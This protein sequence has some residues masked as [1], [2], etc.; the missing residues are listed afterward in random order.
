MTNDALFKWLCKKYGNGEIQPFLKYDRMVKHP[1]YIK[2]LLENEKE[3]NGLY[4]RVK[5]TLKH[6]IVRSEKGSIVKDLENT[7]GAYDVQVVKNSANNVIKGVIITVILRNH[8]WV[9]K[10]GRLTVTEDN[11]MSGK[12]AFAILKEELEKD[13]VK[14]ADYYDDDGEQYKAEIDAYPICNCILHKEIPHVNHIDLNQAWPSALA[15]RMPEFERTFKRIDKKVLNPALGYCQ[16]KFCGFRLAKLPMIGINDTNLRIDDLTDKLID[17][18][19]LIA[20]YNTDGIWYFDATGKNRLYH[21]K[22][23]GLGLHKWK[24]DYTDVTFY[25]HSNGQYYIRKGDKIE[26]K[27]RGYYQY[28]TIKP[29][30]EWDTVD[31]FFKAIASAVEVTWDNDKGLIVRSL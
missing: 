11:N 25:A 30:E 28:E 31:D 19:F 18:D 2:R 24:H 20:G 15:K 7:L 27:L 21:D 17:Q 9:F 23:E 26:Y 1:I 4:F 10:C 29:R 12:R 16:S 14:L 22:D 13:G 6:K 3:V 5:N 8:I